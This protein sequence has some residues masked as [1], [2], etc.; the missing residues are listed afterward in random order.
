MPETDARCTTHSDCIARLTDE[1]QRPQLVVE[2]LEQADHATDGHAREQNVRTVG[3]D[4]KEAGLDV[5]VSGAGSSRM[6]RPL[7][8]MDCDTGAREPPEAAH[9][10]VVLL[11]ES[12]DNVVVYSDVKMAADR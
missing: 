12:V 4:L 8:I 6:L 5:V 9:G 7:V 2:Q 11:V 1:P 10:S 3:L